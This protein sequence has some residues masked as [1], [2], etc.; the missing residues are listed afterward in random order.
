MFNVT[1]V[2]VLPETEYYWIF[3][4]YK[5]MDVGTAIV[6]YPKST[7]ASASI[8]L[9]SVFI[10]PKK[11]SCDHPLNTYLLARLSFSCTALL[12]VSVSTYTNYTN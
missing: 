2:L 9:L 6:A 8:L 10:A 1:D 12:R 11:K 4:I 3:G 7:S 5:K